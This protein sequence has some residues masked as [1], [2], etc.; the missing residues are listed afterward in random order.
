[1]TEQ[2]AEVL[3]RLRVQFPLRSV[4]PAPGGWTAE[5][6]GHDTVTAPGLAD[7]ENQLRR[8]DPPRR[9]TS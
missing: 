1:V 3:A 9:R 6:E 4:R 8:T 7:L 2:K 5:R